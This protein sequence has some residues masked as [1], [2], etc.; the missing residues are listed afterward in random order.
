MGAG[1]RGIGQ[2]KAKM[3]SQQKQMAKVYQGMPNLAPQ[4]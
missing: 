3:S 2:N 1:Q 4:F